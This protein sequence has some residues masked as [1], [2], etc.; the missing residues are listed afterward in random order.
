MGGLSNIN[1]TFKLSANKPIKPLSQCQSQRSF[2]AQEFLI[3]FL[4][5]FASSEL[6]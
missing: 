6:H 5:D 2:I 4:Q 3:F 1:T